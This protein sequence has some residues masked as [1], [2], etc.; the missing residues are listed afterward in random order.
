[1]FPYVADFDRT[2]S[3]LDEFRRRMDHA[4]EGIEPA[5]ALEGPRAALFDAGQALRLEVALPGV[6]EKD[7]RL[8]LERD[9]LTVRAERKDGAPEGYS[10]HRRERA[11]F[12]FS[13]SF[14]LPAKVD[15]EKVTATM[16]KGVLAVELGKA[17]E[18]Q[19][20][21]IQIKAS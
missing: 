9:V 2:F 15:P 5:R 13:R 17:P 11:P 8:T 16:S 1:M 14:A 21:Q 10:V 20:R 7:V 18:A 12:R 19:P 6:T 3:L 4:F